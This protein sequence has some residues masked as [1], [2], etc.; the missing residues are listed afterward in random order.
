MKWF[1]RITS[2]SAIIFL[3]SCTK[4][5]NE[6][7]GVN[8]SKDSVS[9]GAII[10]EDSAENKVQKTEIFN[11]QTELCDNKGY[12]DSNKFS[13]KEL[14][15]TYKLWFQNAGISLNTFSVFSLKDLEKIRK[16]KDLLLAKLDK[17]F[18]ENKKMLENLTV[19]DVSYWQNIKKLKIREL[20]QEYEKNK[21]QMASYSDPS[22]IANNKF[23][24]NCRNFA[25]ALNSSDENIKSEWRKLREAMSK[26]NADPQR[27]INEFGS[28][29]SY[30]N[31]KDYAIIDLITFGW[32]NC[33]NQ[34]IERPLH[35]E[36]MNKEFDA[37]FIKVD[38]EC[39]E[40]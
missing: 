39:D 19:V 11:F 18:T 28:R 34:D 12:F 14:E 23:T 22:V 24:G 29:L 38:S 21:I 31:W 4:E 36:K 3:V 27:I 26:N 6:V 7:S 9:I 15:A 13:H 5:K 2:F 25:E 1:I 8:N 20:H 30:S 33:A 35:D 10:P 32:G 40:P 16:D 37:L 17:D